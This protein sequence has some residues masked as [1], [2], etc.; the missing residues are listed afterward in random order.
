MEKDKKY[1]IKSM[2]VFIA[3]FLLFGAMTVLFLL[4]SETKN[5][6][7]RYAVIG[8][9]LC[10]VAVIGGVLKY[11]D[12]YNKNIKPVKDP[13][14]QIDERRKAH[15]IYADKRLPGKDIYDV[16][17][18]YRRS[19]LWGRLAIIPVC[20]IIVEILM[21]LKFQ[22]VGWDIRWALITGVVTVIVALIIAGKKEMEFSSEDDLRRAIEKS[23]VDPV[24]LNADF[25]MAS[26]FK[27]S[28]GAIFI[29]R[30]YFV[31]FTRKFCS[32]TYMRNILSAQLTREDREVNGNLITNYG[33]RLGFASGSTYDMNIGDKRKA[34]V[35]LDE[36]EL[37]GIEIL[38][39][40]T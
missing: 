16:F 19:F 7:R 18:R 21:V 23:K 22:E 32:V 33:L 28:Y 31:M 37:R 3:G 14:S 39:D 35:M 26:S 13:E 11:T 5:G 40:R 38:G 4:S 8:I 17:R 20:L 27:S 10:V 36:L 6:D 29:G 15:R 12:Y 25:M 30:D 24:R 9:V 1:F 2:A 34:S